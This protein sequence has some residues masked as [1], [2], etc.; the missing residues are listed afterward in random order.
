MRKNRIEQ[1]RFGFEFLQQYHEDSDKF[2]NH[3]ARVT[4]DETSV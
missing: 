2:L 1:L 3:T 4:G